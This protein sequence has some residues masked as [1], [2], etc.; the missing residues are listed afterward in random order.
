MNRLLVMILGLM[1]AVSCASTY[2]CQ[3]FPAGKCQSVGEV[4]RQQQHA[5]EQAPLMANVADVSQSPLE[6]RP[7]LQK[8]QVLR[9]LVN[10]WIDEDRDLHV[11]GFIYVKLNDL[12]WELP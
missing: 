6:D 9:I 8:P 4:Y 5:S 7:L 12:Q 3:D 1:F 11:G 2:Q 10:N